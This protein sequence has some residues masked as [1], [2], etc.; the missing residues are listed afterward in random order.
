MT[1]GSRAEHDEAGAVP[2]VYL[3][4]VGQLERGGHDSS[5][6]EMEGIGA[7]ILHPFRFNIQQGQ[8][9]KQQSPPL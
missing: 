9:L 1:K 6:V 7:H 5:L 3:E 4:M 8:F 2:V